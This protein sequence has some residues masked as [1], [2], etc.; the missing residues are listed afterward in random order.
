MS[1]TQ[2][3]HATSNSAAQT[4]T[5]VSTSTIFRGVKLAALIPIL[6]GAAYL[7]GV[8]YYE[9][10]IKAFGLPGGVIAKSASEYFVFAHIAITRLL[11]KLI[12][13]IFSSF[14]WVSL[15]FVAVLVWKGMGAA[16]KYFQQDPKIARC[17]AFF[18]SGRKGRFIGEAVLVPTLVSIGLGYLI[19]IL[20]IILVIPDAVGVT[21]GRLAGE[22]DRKIYQAGC[23]TV[24]KSGDFCNE[25][26]DGKIVMQ[27]F[28]LDVSDKYLSFYD[29][30]TNKA[31]TVPVN[32]FEF[33]AMR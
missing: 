28:I 8:R 16:D 29:P 3:Q 30:K 32:S 18:N 27:V 20:T 26:S 24:Q 12:T 15:V 1:N 19:F 4:E 23:P 14:Q 25:I 21:A 22:E 9:A 13:Y 5:K 6:S 7:T 17:R 31:R 2:V 11:L 10:Y 33:Q